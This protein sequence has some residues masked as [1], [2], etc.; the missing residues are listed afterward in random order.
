MEVTGYKCFNTDLTNKYGIKFEVGKIYIASGPLKY[1]NNGNGY[2]LCR[3][4]EDTLRYFD[5][6][7]DEVKICR[8]KGSE[9][10]LE[11]SDDYYGY[12]ELFVARKLEILNLLTRKEI[13]DLELNLNN[14]FRVERFISLF[15]LN[16]EEIKKFKDIYKKD[17]RVLEAIEYYQKN[18]LDIYKRG[19]K[20]YG[21][22]SNKR[23][24]R[25]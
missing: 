8:V 16:D 10:I 18:D 7:N 15:R 9:E 22:Y 2:H 13:I 5:A 6:M 11:E 1:G 19:V 21:Q 12:Y 23:S 25:E 24:K 14:G 4:L 20:K 3:N 17:F